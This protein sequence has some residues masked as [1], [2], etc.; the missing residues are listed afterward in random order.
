MQLKDE[1]V[2]LFCDV[3]P[4]EIR[5]EI[6]YPPESAALPTSQ[7]PFKVSIIINYILQQIQILL[8]LCL[9]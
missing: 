5:S 8:N 6:V 4:L 3:T 1:V 2:V 7:Q 9:Y